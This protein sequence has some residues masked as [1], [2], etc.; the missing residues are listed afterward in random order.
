VFVINALDKIA[1]ARE[2][3]RNKALKEAVQTALSKFLSFY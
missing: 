2:A 3:K 1:N